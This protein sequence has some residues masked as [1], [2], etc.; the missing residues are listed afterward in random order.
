MIV[1]GMLDSI[2]PMEVLALIEAIRLH[3]LTTS[4]SPVFVTGD[5]A[6]THSPRNAAID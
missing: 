4:Q 3:P 1:Y 6:V 5:F 2:H